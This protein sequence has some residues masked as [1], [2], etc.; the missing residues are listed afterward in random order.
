M[1]SA[2]VVTP[3]WQQSLMVTANDGK[4]A[5]LELPH[6]VGMW[7]E[8]KPLPVELVKGKNVLRFAH[9][10]HGYEKGFSIKEFTLAPAG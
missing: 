1:L 9:K 4:A 2:Q 3:S 7:E 8:T 10:A 6:T 5:E